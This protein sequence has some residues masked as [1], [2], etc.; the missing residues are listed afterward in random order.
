MRHDRSGNDQQPVSPRRASRSIND[1]LP[2]S[3]PSG[4]TVLIILAC[5]ATL[6]AA[7]FMAHAVGWF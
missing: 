2:T 1:D 3:S 7:A 6:V 4:K 5:I